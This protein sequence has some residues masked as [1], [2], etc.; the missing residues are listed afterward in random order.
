M[1]CRPGENPACSAGYGAQHGS[2][3]RRQRCGERREAAT[4]PRLG[5]AFFAFGFFRRSMLPL[6]AC[7]LPRAPISTE[8]VRATTVRGASVAGGG[9]FDG[10]GASSGGL[11]LRY[12]RFRH[13]IPASFG[14]VHPVMGARE[15]C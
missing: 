4:L 14:F 6:E 10:D 8:A 2:C 5:A 7:D 13:G 3:W 12:V 15:T 1:G 11:G 9:D